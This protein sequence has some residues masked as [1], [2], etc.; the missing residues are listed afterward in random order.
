MMGKSIVL[1]GPRGSGKTVIGKKLSETLNVDFLDADD[2]FIKVFGEIYDFTETKGWE[3]F[4]RY[5]SRIIEKVCSSYKKQIVFS[6]GGGSVAHNQGEE[7]REKNISLLSSF[8]TVVYLLPSANLE[9]SARILYERTKKDERTEAQRPSLTEKK[10]PFQE[11]LEKVKE[12]HRFY[13]YA[14]HALAYTKG[15]TIEE[16]AEEISVFAR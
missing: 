7:Y 14:S 5:E 12:R 2:L 10:D 1:V 3:K 6:T 11:M 4:R 9:E 8:G 15:K 16:V 13:I